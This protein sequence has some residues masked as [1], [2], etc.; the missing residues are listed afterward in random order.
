MRFVQEKSSAQAWKNR[1]LHSRARPPP[2]LCGTR[3]LQGVL[4]NGVAR[5]TETS[6]KTYDTT[7]ATKGSTGDEQEAAERRRATSVTID[8]RTVLP[9]PPRQL[10]A[11]TTE[12]SAELCDVEEHKH[13]A[14]TN[15]TIATQHD[16]L[17]RTR[18][19]VTTAMTR[20]TSEP[21]MIH[22]GFRRSATTPAKAEEGPG[23]T[24][25]LT[26]PAFAGECV[27]ASTSS[28]RSPSPRADRRQRCPLAAAR[29]RVW[30]SG[31]R[32][33]GGRQRG[34]AV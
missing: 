14:S 26:M 13:R 20:T 28:T 1:W 25:K 11:G 18:R 3:P 30:R 12:R 17:R 33:W 22:M 8:Q 29:S 2:V 15:A 4:L 34:R 5:D 21:I 19:A 16:R 31:K 7:S 24:R 27:T 6:E 10:P 32:A 9:R 23:T